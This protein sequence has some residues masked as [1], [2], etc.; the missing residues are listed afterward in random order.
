MAKGSEDKVRTFLDREWLRWTRDN[1]YDHKSKRH[2]F[3]AY[4]G[5]EVVGYVDLAI[6]GG[7]A[8]YGQLIVSGSARHKGIGESLLRKAEDC[9]K[10]N[11]CHLAYLDTHERNAAA[12]R[13]Y[14]KNG[15]ED[16]AVMPDNKFHFTW[17]ILAKRL[18]R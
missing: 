8:H 5:R 17:Y 11:G 14:H 12:L 10:A 15:Y 18:R 6:M 13:L 7:C 3:V 16:I 1:G 2:A 9:A 4:V